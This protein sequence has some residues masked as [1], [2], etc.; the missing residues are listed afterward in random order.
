MH[1]LQIYFMQIGILMHECTLRTL[2]SDVYTWVLRNSSN[3]ERKTNFFVI[4]NL[5]KQFEHDLPKNC[6]AP[7]IRVLRFTLYTTQI[8]PVTF[9]VKISSENFR[10]FRNFL[11]TVKERKQFFYCLQ[12][13][14]CPRLTTSRSS[15]MASRVTM[16]NRLR[17]MRYISWTVMSLW[18]DSHSAVKYLDGKT[19][20]I[21]PHSHCT[22]HN[23]K[24]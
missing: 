23:K 10:I 17:T 8:W 21:T 1:L 5:W 16:R 24:C 14:K 15:L 18:A 4:R 6:L 3:L 19:K 13:V 20:N 11:C 2:Y 9:I 7:L 12:S 22:E